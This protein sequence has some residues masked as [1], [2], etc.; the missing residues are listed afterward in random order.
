MEISNFEELINGDVEITF[1]YPPEY[2]D[3]I[4]LVFTEDVMWEI[5]KYCID[6]LSYG[7]KSK[8][9]RGNN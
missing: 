3:A 2:G 7:A 1:A 9:Q 5:H 6:N 8:K 4:K